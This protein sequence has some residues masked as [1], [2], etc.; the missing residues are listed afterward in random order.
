MWTN[1]SVY[2]DGLEGGDDGTP[3]DPEANENNG[4][5]V[6]ISAPNTPTF[7]PSPTTTATPTGTPANTN[8]PTSTATPCF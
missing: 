8:T 1:V 2:V 5:T 6:C 4:V 3:V 7:T